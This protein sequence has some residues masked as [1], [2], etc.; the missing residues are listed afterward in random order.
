MGSLLYVG[1]DFTVIAAA[2]IVGLTVWLTLNR[3]QIGKIV[4]A[5][6]HGAEI[7]QIMGVDVKRI[8]PGAFMAGAFLAALGGALTAPMI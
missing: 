4:L 5:V 6:I 3:T 2:V 1:Y 7:N 8:Y